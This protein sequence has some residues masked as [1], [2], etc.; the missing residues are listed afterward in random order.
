MC[1][2]GNPSVM[3]TISKC[4]VRWGVWVQKRL[5]RPILTLKSLWNWRQDTSAEPVPSLQSSMRWQLTWFM[6]FADFRSITL[7]CCLQTV[8]NQKL[9]I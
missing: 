9:I 5:I 8:N 7:D 1:P 3:M 2:G 4:Q 6:T